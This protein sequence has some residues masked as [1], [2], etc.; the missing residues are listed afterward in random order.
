MAETKILC[1]KAGASRFIKTG[2]TLA[3]E[4]HY[5]NGFI[6]QPQQTK[7]TSPMFFQFR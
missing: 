1:C 3:G 6:R 4:C 2:K 5:G 7:L